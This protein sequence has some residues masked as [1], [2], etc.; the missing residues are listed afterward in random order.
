MDIVSMMEQNESSQV[1]KRRAFTIL[2]PLLGGIAL[3]VLMIL[4]MTVS[5][6]QNVLVKDAEGNFYRARSLIVAG[7]VVLCSRDPSC[8]Q[9]RKAALD[10][11]SEERKLS[12]VSMKNIA[13]IEIISAPDE[14]DGLGVWQPGLKDFIGD[15]VVNAAGNHG[16]LSLRASGGAVYGTIRFPD[17]GRGATEYLKGVRIAG[18]KIF[19]TRSVTTAQELKRVGANAYFT[20]QYSGEYYQSG[21]LIKGYYA[22]QGARKQ[23]EAQKK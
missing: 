21:K 1:K 22:V 23:W 8:Y 18:G 10:S 2:L 4:I 3:T 9:T 7:P 12:A 11:A 17:W 13:F 19:F 15:Y 16:Y 5:A 14:G 20:Q 6:R